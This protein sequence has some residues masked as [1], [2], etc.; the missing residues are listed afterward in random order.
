MTQR[1]KVQGNLYNAVV[2]AGA[3]YVGRRGPS[4]P[5]SPYAN[6]HKAGYCCP[7]RT[8]HDRAG[9]ITAYAHDLAARPAMVAAARRDLAGRDLA[10][11]CR[12]SDPC[13]GDILLTVAA[14]QDP[15]AALDALLGV[16]TGGAR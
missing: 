10:C 1:V 6:L 5:G 14:G 11:W 7:C 4:L 9:S 8:T 16:A 12:L 3:V 15:L 2:P 13:H